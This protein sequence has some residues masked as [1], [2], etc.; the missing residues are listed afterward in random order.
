MCNGGLNDRLSIELQLIVSRVIRNEYAYLYC[1]LCQY[2]DQLRVSAYR[3][4]ATKILSNS[5]HD[6]TLSLSPIKFLG[7]YFSSETKVN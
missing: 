7:Y 3:L 2:F 5:V 6:L 4:C 1:E